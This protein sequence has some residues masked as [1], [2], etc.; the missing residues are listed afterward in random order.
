MEKP[1]CTV[2]KIGNILFVYDPA[3]PDDQSGNI[4]RQITVPLKFL[5][6]RES[7]KYKGQKNNLVEGLVEDSEM[8]PNKY[9]AIPPTLNWMKNE[10]STCPKLN[11]PD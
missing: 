10:S 6:K 5:G 2:E 9:P 7:E 8:R 11:S 4:Y 3:I 1:G